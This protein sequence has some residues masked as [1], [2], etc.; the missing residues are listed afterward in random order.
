MLRR[1]WSLSVNAGRSTCKTRLPWEPHASHKNS[2]PRSSRQGTVA[3]PSGFNSATL[4]AS[5]IKGYIMATKA[6]T[7]AGRVAERKTSRS[8]TPNR[9]KE[10]RPAFPSAIELLEE[11]HRQ[12]EEWFDE[13]D[14]LK[15]DDDH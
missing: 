2:A 13:Y 10:T 8:Q 15:E 1:A 11:D 9:K 5:S 3:P 7:K 14:E 6:K 4:I 12:V